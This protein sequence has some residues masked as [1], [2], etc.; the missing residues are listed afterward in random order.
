MKQSWVEREQ[1][2]KN[3]EMEPKQKQHPVVDETGDGSNV[4]CLK[5]SN[6]T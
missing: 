2:R 5:E 6:I 3:I 1:M 4:W